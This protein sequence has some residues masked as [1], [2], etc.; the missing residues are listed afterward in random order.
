MNSVYLL[1]IFGETDVGLLLLSAEKQSISASFPFIQCQLGG[2][3]G[4]STPD[5]KIDILET[6]HK[7]I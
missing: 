1:Y 7:K 5:R 6:V 3:W 2:G 4:I